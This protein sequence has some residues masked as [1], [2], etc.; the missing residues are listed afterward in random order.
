[1]DFLV[2]NKNENTEET[3]NEKN[4]FLKKLYPK[5]ETLNVNQ[6]VDASFDFDDY[7]DNYEIERTA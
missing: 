1:M 5:V 7:S 2:K 6:K 3:L 4:I